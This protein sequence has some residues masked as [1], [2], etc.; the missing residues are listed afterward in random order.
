MGVI[1]RLHNN[2]G[3]WLMFGVEVVACRENSRGMSSCTLSKT[4]CTG[5]FAD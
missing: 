1:P 3:R 5:V 2:L 4:Y